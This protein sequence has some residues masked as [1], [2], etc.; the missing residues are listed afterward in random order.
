M[1]KNKD[2][3]RKTMTRLK[4]TK[5]NKNIEP[6]SRTLLV[7]YSLWKRAKDGAVACIIHHASEHFTHNNYCACP[8]RHAS[9]KIR[10]PHGIFI[11]GN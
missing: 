5:D 1:P 4:F 7:C 6:R 9:G 8:L 3:I 2:K 11:S 10:N